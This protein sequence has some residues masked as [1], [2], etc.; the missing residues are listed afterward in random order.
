MR[1]IECLNLNREE[2]DLLTMFRQLSIEQRLMI[3]EAAEECV[4]RNDRM[5]TLAGSGQ[6]RGRTVDRGLM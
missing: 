5:E 1:R 6:E 2:V 4:T 3:L